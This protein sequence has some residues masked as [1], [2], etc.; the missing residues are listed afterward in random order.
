MVTGAAGFVGSAVCRVALERG[1]DVLGLV[2]RNDE[3]TIDIPT[4]LLNLENSN[5]LMGVMN[6]YR[7]DYVIHAAGSASVHDSFERPAE[8]FESSA[9]RFGI[10]CLRQR[11]VPTYLQVSPFVSSAAVYGEPAHLPVSEQDS[12]QPISPYGFHKRICE[13]LAEQYVQCHGLSIASARVFSLIG[14]NQRRLLA[15]G[16]F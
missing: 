10:A 9:R 8:N 1:I 7:P 13:L 3:R 2:R 4:R 11:D 6:E 12:S 5:D 14:P 16:A 15:W